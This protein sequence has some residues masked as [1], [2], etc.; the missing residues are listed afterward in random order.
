MYKWKEVYWNN[1]IMS[2]YPRPI[3]YRLSHTDYHTDFHVTETTTKPS[4]GPALFIPHV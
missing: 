4:H 3:A 1:E 2:L